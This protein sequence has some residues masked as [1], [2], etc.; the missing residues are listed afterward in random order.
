MCINDREELQDKKE[1]AD[2]VKIKREG[3]KTVKGYE[4]EQRP[5]SWT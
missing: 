3:D 4:K 2:S 5:N 1:Y